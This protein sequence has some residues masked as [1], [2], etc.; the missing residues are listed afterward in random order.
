MVPCL[1][2]FPLKKLNIKHNLFWLFIGSV[3]SDVI[4]KTASFLNIWSGRGVAH[5]FLFFIVTFIALQLVTKDKIKTFSYGVGFIIHIIMD[6]PL[7]VFFYPLTGNIDFML[8][9]YVNFSKIDYFMGLLLSNKVLMITELMG[10][11]FLISLGFYTLIKNYFYN[12]KEDNK[13][14]IDYVEIV[15]VPIKEIETN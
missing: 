11:I 15:V 13:F 1:L 6:L 3:I 14:Y 7:P 12:L 10:F 4:D 9:P 8:N 2:I 5:T